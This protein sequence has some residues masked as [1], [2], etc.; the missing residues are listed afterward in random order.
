VHDGFGVRG[1]QPGGDLNPEIDDFVR[2]QPLAVNA[3]P[4]GL[5][6]EQLHRNEVPPLVLID[7]VDRTDIGMIQRRGG[8]R[9]AL[10][11]LDRLAVAGQVLRQE[12][13]RDG[14]LEPQILGPVDDAHAAGTECLDDPVMR[15]AFADHGGSPH[16]QAA[17]G[18]DGH[19]ISPRV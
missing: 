1:L 18:D 12:L 2:L 10:E 4:E 11:A 15:D 8:A 6:L 3:L 14:A 9:F 16:R 19:L 5:A 13:Q 7:V 17:H